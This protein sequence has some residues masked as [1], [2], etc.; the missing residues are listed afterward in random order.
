[1][2]T[3]KSIGVHMRNVSIIG[4]GFTPPRPL[5]PEQSYREMIFEAATKAYANAGLEPKDI[6]GFVT[7]AEDFLE[8]TSIFDEYTPDQLGAVQRPVHTI[9]GDGLY[10][11]IAGYLKIQTGLMDVVMIEVHSKASNILTY[12]HI[13][14]YALDPIYNRPLQY[15]PH[16]LAALEM[17]YFLNQTHTDREAVAAVA[18]KNKKNALANSR[19]CFG[20]RITTDD[21]LFS[22]SR[23]EPITQL[24]TAQHTD[25]ACVIILAADEKVRGGSK[26]PIRIS[27][28]GWISDSPAP[29]QQSWV[30]PMYA[31]K[32]AK[33]AFKMAN[34]SNPLHEID[35]SG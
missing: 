12:D 17:T 19:S 10:G 29:E 27:G 21:V 5:T 26:T 23:F 3:P 9:T 2:T 15:H 32:S 28:V 1:M 31:A 24:E 22:P 33:A 6:D 25:G 11:I 7:C 35:F 16:A 8:G 18:V 14:H 4:I 20:G 34:I 30:H 13:I